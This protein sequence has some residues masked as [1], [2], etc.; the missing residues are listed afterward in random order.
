MIERRSLLVGTFSVLFA[1]K[2][3]LIYTPSFD[4]DMAHVIETSFSRYKTEVECITDWMN[5]FQQEV[6]N[7]MKVWGTYK[8]LA[9]ITF[10]GRPVNLWHNP[11]FFDECHIMGLGTD[12]FRISF[13]DPK[14]E[15]ITVRYRHRDKEFKFE[16]GEIA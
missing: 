2:I 14:D 5:I 16:K 11:N 9:Q 1:N 8:P 3:P 6:E 15:I 4:D 13:K 10:E 7:K 12:G